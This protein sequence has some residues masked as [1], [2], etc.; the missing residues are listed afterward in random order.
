[1]RKELPARPNLEHLR[2]QAKAL[3]AKLREGDSE[4][5]R[6]FIHHLP[7]AELPE[8]LPEAEHAAQRIAVRIY[9]ADKENPG[10]IRQRPH[11]GRRRLKVLAHRRTLGALVSSSSSSDSSLYGWASPA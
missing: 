8:A 10:V 3:L 9:M 1:M 6:A 5:A 7:E 4:A 2:T 11:R